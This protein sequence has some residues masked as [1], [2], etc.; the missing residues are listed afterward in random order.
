MSTRSLSVAAAGFGVASFEAF[1][2]TAA[3]L[4]CSR[5][6]NNFW[7][8][9]VIHTALGQRSGARVCLS[10]NEEGVFANFGGIG[11]K[12]TVL[13]AGECR[14]KATEAVVS[15]TKLDDYFD[16]RWA[17]RPGPAVVK[18]DCEASG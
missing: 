10:N 8:M 9:E 1:P 7:N 4:Q 14:S 5:M 12:E 2:P 18:V 6:L 15:L 11:A 3:R 13:G 16:G 17:G